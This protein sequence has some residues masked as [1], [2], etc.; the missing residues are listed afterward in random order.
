LRRADLQQGFVVA[1]FRTPPMTHADFPA[2]RLASAA[3]GE[4]F[5]GRIFTNLRDRRGLAYACGASLHH[6]RLAGH[7]TLYIGTKPETIDAAREGLLEEA[8]WIRENT[9]TPADMERAREYVIGKFVMGLQSHAQRAGRLAGWEDLV[10]QAEAAERWPDQ[11]RA[12]TADDVRAAAARWWTDPTVA[13]L[14]PE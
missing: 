12:V 6:H 4:G 3:L 7:Q 8:A 9:L 11:L 13:V 10:G 1:G 14:R 2:L 5:A